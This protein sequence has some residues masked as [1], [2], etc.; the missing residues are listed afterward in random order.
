MPEGM[1][2]LMNANM[3]K[4][5]HSHFVLQCEME[6]IVE[7]GMQKGRVQ[8]ELKLSFKNSNPCSLESYQNYSAPFRGS[9]M[10]KVFPIEHHPMTVVGA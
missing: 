5:L 3:I 2:A 6:S 4:N 8:S 10:K 7:H 1:T 9:N